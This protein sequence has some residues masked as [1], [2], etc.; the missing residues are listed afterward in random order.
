MLL[1]N[2]M[3]QSFVDGLVP[4]DHLRDQALREL[5]LASPRRDPWLL[6]LVLQAR[7]LLRAPMAAVAVVSGAYQYFIATVGVGTLWRVDRQDPF[8]QHALHADGAFV[9]HDALDEP[10]FRHSPLVTGFPFLRSCAGAPI[11][12]ANG[13]RIGAFWIMDS[14][15]LRVDA[16]SASLLRGYADRT[17]AHFEAGAAP[18][19]YKP[20]NPVSLTVRPSAAA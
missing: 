7:A 4:G 14:R 16:R 12:A 15:P 10:E 1:Q 20:S 19:G 6:P 3:P 9:I 5:G 13:A 11:D 17:L 2:V 8:C 18:E